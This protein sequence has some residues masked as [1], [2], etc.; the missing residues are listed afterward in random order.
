MSPRSECD[1]KGATLVVMRVVCLCVV[2]SYIMIKGRPCKVV[3]V[4]TSKTGKHGHA[5]ANFTAIDIFNGKKLEDIIP[6]THTTYC[7]NVNRA[8]FQLLDIAEDGFCSLLKEDGETRDDL[9][10]PDYPE[11]F[12]Q[13][14]KKAF[15]DG[16]T[17]VVTVLSACGIDQIIAYK[18]EN[19]A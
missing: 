7:P 12:D 2:C 13:E 17:L 9:K 4:S 18:E 1:V 11:G 6:T 3:N 19:A 15:D 14:I 5:K 16:K 10:L 8:E